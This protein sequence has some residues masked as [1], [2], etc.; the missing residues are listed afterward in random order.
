MGKGF[1]ISKPLGFVLFG[2]GVGAVLTIFALSV[3]YSQEKRKNEVNARDGT[4]MV[5]TA[6]P[7]S[8]SAPSNEPWDKYRL[9]DTLLP[10]Y[11]NVTLWPR[12]VPDE[13]GMYIFTGKS[14]VALTCVKETNLIIIHSNELNFTLTSE[15]HHAK[16]AGLGGTSAPVILKTWFQIQTQFMVILLKDN[17]Q[18]GKSYW[19]YM[20]FRGELSDDLGGFY[21]S[22]YTENGVKKV[23]ATTQ[24]QP[25]AARNAFPCFD[26]PSMKA[27][28]HLTLL[29]PPGTVALANGMELDTENVTIDD[30]EVLQTRFEP[31]EKMS[32]YLLAFV[33]SEFTN[34]RSPSEANV[35]IRIWGRREAIESGQGDYALS[36]TFPILKY[37]E[38]YYN[39]TYPLSKSDQ[40]ALPDFAAGA[41]ENWGLVTYREQSLFYDPKVSSNEDK[42][43]VVTVI[44]HELA[45]MW[46]GNLVTMR[47]WNDLWLNEGFASYVSYLGADYAEPTWNIK[48]LMV[49]QQVQRAFGVDALV[50]SHPLSSR[51]DEVITPDQIDQLFD[52]ITYSKGAAVLRML[53]EFL[54]ESAFAKGLHNYLHEYA[55]SN[56]VYT[57]LWKK[58]QEVVDAD[59]SIQLPA[60][61]NE[62]MNRWILQMGFPV[63]TIN[64]RTGIIS[65]QHFLIHPDAVVDKPSDYN[66]EWF[67][68]ITWMKSGSNMGQHWLLTKTA[69]YEPMKTDTD[70]LLANLNVTGYYRVNYDPQNWERLLTQLTA[71]HKIIPVLN[72]GQIIDDAFNLA[73]AQIINITLA[74]RTTKY[75]YEEKEYI[76]WESAIRNF[77]YFF[78]MFD[79][80]EVYGPLQ[81]YLQ[82]KVKPLFDHFKVITSNWTRKPP[83]YMDQYN[84]IN[85]VS[86]AC[87]TGVKGCSELT[88]MWYRQWMKNPDSNPIPTNLK[89]TVYCNAI[90]AGGVEEWDFG[91]Q[92]FKNSTIAAEAEKLLYGLSCTKEPWLLN[93]YLEF[94]IEPNLVRKQDVAFAIVYISGNVIGQPLVW[95]FVRANWEHLTKDYDDGSFFFGRLIRGITRKFSTEFDLQQLQRFKEDIAASSFSFGTQAIEQA[96]EQTKANI[97]W[98]SE[99]KVQVMN[100]LIEQSA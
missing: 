90:A 65:Q 69:S 57:D 26:E 15:M 9:P 64:T 52:T 96:I 94:T 68:P 7:H 2:L 20:E 85:A 77:E 32:T 76:P 18:V 71:D 83:R 11:Y 12:L 100:W 70:W 47:W 95:D 48:D 97:K 98:V 22:Q 46:F 86:M 59:S 81:T 78:L 34:L 82:R 89:I 10:A 37:L 36:V 16:L 30:Q 41:M 55:Y 54:T 84:Q 51:E 43:W 6:A 21:R 1:Y 33:I 25:T 61:I 67:V 31:T 42:E 27:V 38:N 73:R 35:L 17:L 29:H 14:G 87:K 92:M 66:Y 79:R 58:L 13:Q 50:S 62:I 3:V 23:V 39:T 24:M 60:S 75:L 19:L 5:T 4:R 53:S 28:F 44:T 91:W 8:T 93:R 40:V 49:L 72:R 63:V 74:L 56:T 80:T 45:H 99:N 88:R